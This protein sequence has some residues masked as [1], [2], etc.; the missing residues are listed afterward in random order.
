MS[1]AAGSDVERER[2]SAA[3]DAGELEEVAPIDRLGKS[4]R[5]HCVAS[6]APPAS[7]AARLIPARIRMYVAQRQRLFVMALS[8]S[9]SVG[10]GLSF[11]SAAAVMIWPAWQ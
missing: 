3:G 4:G 5:A 10:R 11:R 6:F 2:Q 8:M 9:A 1:F 7:S